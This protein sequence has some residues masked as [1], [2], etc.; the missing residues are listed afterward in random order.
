[1]C[2][3]GFRVR[4]PGALRRVVTTPVRDDAVRDLVQDD[5]GDQH[6]EE[7]Q[8][9]LKVEGQRSGAPRRTVDA[10]ARL[11]HRLEPGVADRLATVLAEP[12]GAV[13]DAVERLLH[14]RELVFERAGERAS[15]ADLGGHLSRV[16]EV[17]VEIRTV[18][19]AAER[20]E[21]RLSR[22][23]SASRAARFVAR[24]SAG[25]TSTRL[26]APLR[27]RVGVLVHRP[28]PLGAHQGVHLRR[29]DRRVAEQLLHGPDVG[30]VVEHVGGA[31][32]A[33]HVRAE[34]VAEADAVAVA[35]ARSPT[36]PGARADRP[37]RSGTPPRRRRAG[38]T[39]RARARPGHSARAS[40]S[41]ASA[42][43]RPIGTTRSWL[44]LPKTRSTRSPRS[45]SPSDSPTSSEM[46]MPVP[47]STSRMARSRRASGS[48]PTTDARSD[49]TSSS[50]ERLRQ[51]LGHLRRLD[52]GGRVAGD[53][54]LVGEE[55]V[56]R[57]HGD[58][59][60]RDRGRRLAVAAAGSAT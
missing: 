55:A 1:M 24:S 47:Y 41:S 20:G 12:V 53:A 26:T 33:Q 17:V 31:R 16:G 56:Q 40:P 60:P 34:P 5:R 21:L 6:P 43:N 44:P 39:A 46:R 28:Q 52:V 14:R 7:D 57:A 23:F 38:P 37:A 59:R 42:A 54:A 50:L 30:A 48:S 32:V 15:L 58:E 51:P 2:G 11:R 10:P 36:R 19:A 18:G 25:G 27:P 8:G 49:S 22:S 3:I 9:G 29:R 13:V 4:R 35:R 45:T